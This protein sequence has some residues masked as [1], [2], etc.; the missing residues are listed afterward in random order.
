MFH[1]PAGAAGTQMRA[2]LEPGMSKSSDPPPSRPFSFQAKDFLEG[3][4]QK[5]LDDAKAVRSKDEARNLKESAESPPPPSFGRPNFAPVGSAGKRKEEHTILMAAP[6]PAQEV[7][8]PPLEKPERKEEHTILMAVPP[9]AQEV[10]LPSLEKVKRKEE[11]TI[12]MTVPPPA[13]ESDG[14]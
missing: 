3:A 13:Q 9:P 14:D 5:L 8:L 1:P 10:V 12:L 7:V 6:P 4:P 2:A 11:H